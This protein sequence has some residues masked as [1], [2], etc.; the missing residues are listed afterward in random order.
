MSALPLAAALPPDLR[1]IERDWLSSNQI[2]FAGRDAT[3][4]VDSGYLTHA[5]TTLALVRHALG[6]RPL[7][8][9]Y[10]THLHSDHCGGNATLQRAYGCRTAVPAGAW[11]AARDWDMRRLTYEATGQRCERFAV[12][13]AI[14]PGSVLRLGDHDWQALAAPG[15]DPTSIVLYQPDYRTLLSADA[16]WEHGFGVIFPELE[17]DSGFAEQRA[18]LDLIAQLDVA[19]AIPGH[20]RAFADVGAALQRAYAR[21]DYLSADP[22]RNARHALKVLVKFLLLERRAIGLE[23]VEQVLRDASYFA[24][25]NERFFRLPLPALAQQA[26]ESLVA[27]GTA[28]IQ[29]G[30]LVNA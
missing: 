9:L 3:A 12:D 23:T 20:G 6:G 2:L 28:R 14:A 11:Q 4:L 30:V 21:L 10:N 13:A 15:H 16:L 5:G 7:D 29:D 27:T 24:A 18:T 25:M 17:G 1:M 26:V 22:L 19:V 8:A